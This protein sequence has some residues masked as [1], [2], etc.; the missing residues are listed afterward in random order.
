MIIPMSEH[1]WCFPPVNHQKTRICENKEMSKFLTNLDIS[2]T[3]HDPVH[4]LLGQSSRFGNI[5][6]QKRKS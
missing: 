1:A 4:L 5:I 6:L 2:S 3:Q